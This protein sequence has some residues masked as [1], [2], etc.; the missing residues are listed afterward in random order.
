LSPMVFKQVRSL[1]LEIRI[2]GGLLCWLW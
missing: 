1:A 2:A